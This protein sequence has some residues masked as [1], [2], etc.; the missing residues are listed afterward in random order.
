MYQLNDLDYG[1]VQ[2][3]E[4]PYRGRVGY[5]DDSDYFDS[6]DELDDLIIN[7]PYALDILGVASGWVYFFDNKNGTF[8]C[9]IPKKHL[10]TPTTS[11][12]IER[13]KEVYR[14]ME[15]INIRGEQ[16]M[17]NSE[18]LSESSY[19]DSLL[20]T[21][22]LKIKD[23]NSMHTSNIFLSH[24]SVDKEFAKR[25]FADLKVNGHTPWLDTYEI[26]VGEA[27]PQRISEG[28]KE[29][30]F[31]IVVLS[32]ESVKSRWVEREWQTK[33]W[34]EVSNGQ[35]HVLPVLYQDCEIPELM[36]TKKY[37]D[38]R[39]N[40]NDGLA[41]VLAGIQN[42]SSKYKQCVQNT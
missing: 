32:Q 27:I 16:A 23:I 9:L 17:S 28:I 21:S 13:R 38:F 14:L 26:S 37:A 29:A 12:L 25:L 5:Y 35:I 41:D 20:V 33:Y 30:D 2:V 22:I 42:L 7:S 34:D 11:Q 6:V 24:S 39:D 36:K 18:L 4:G 1:P 40:Y 10:A 8:N 19:I 3:L 31:I 15:D